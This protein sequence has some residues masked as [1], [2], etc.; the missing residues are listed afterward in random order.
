MKIAPVAEVAWVRETLDDDARLTAAF[1]GT[2]GATFR[3]KGPE[4]DRGRARLSAGVTA[5]LTKTADLHVGYA[6]EIADSDA[7]HAFS[8][9][10]RMAW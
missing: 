7:G 5:Q 3:I 9:G 10:F 2:T 8:A 6:G 4:L 1:A